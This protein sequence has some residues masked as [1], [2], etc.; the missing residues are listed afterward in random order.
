MSDVKIKVLDNGPYL[1]SGTVE[2]LD[3]A[4][5][6]ITKPE[7]NMP[8]IVADYQPICLFVQGRTMVN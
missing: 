1:V 5:K 6:P 7:S 4:D 2:I 3:G 8:Y